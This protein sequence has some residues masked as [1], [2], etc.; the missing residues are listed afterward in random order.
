[1]PVGV[2]P[3]HAPGTG[4]DARGRPL[5]LA[6][7]ANLEHALAYALRFDSRGKAWRADL[8]LRGRGLSGPCPVAARLLAHLALSNYVV[9]QGPPSKPAYASGRG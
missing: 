8:A 7:A 9:M 6:N 3:V 1:M 2:R 4:T 5:T